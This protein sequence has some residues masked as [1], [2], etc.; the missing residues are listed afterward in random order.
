MAKKVKSFTR[1]EVVNRLNKKISCGGIILGSA[2]ANSISAINCEISGVDLIAIYNSG[3]FNTTGGTL[4]GLLPF[5]DANKIVAE[6]GNEVLPA[7]KN[8]PVLAG[9]CGFN[10]FMVIDKYL[11][12]LKEQGFCGVQNFP[13]V[14]LIDG[15]F[16][17]NLDYNNFNYNL[18]INMIS[19]AHKLDMF[20]CPFVFNEHDAES[21]AKAGA[22]CIVADMG[23]ITNGPIGKNT[24]L[25]LDDCVEKIA[26]V[27]DAGKAINPNILVMCHGGPII[28][29][30]DVQYILS[31]ITGIDGFFDVAR[32][33][34]APINY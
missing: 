17:I 23:L 3:R 9:V 25:S 26:A 2:A 10:P 13:T 27:C 28:K 29:P 24:A 14:G 6:I 7:V 32:I 30:D 34:V 21:M 11:K 18:E 33:S 1:E 31:K 16:R 12:Q 22:D 8:T 5:G 15:T 4:E 20:T 19:K